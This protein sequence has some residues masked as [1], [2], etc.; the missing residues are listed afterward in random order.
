MESF[1][2]WK[3]LLDGR[4]ITTSDA[5]HAHIDRFKRRLIGRR[6]QTFAI[7]AA[8]LATRL[9]FS[10]GIALM[11]NTVGEPAHPP[12]H[13]LLR[14]PNSGPN[15]WPSVVVGG[16]RSIQ[17]QNWKWTKGTADSV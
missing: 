15:E 3:L 9:T 10:N 6:L 14:L 13:W 11:T 7:D 1:A 16:T 17:R 2:A 4:Q 8:S 5:M 12:S